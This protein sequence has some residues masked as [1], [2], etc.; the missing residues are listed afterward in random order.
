ML[1]IGILRKIGITEKLE[2]FEMCLNVYREDGQLGRQMKGP[3]EIL[4]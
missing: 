2:I 3:D 4:K 1:K